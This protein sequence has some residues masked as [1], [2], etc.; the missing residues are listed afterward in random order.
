[1]SVRPEAIVYC[2]GF[3]TSFVLSTTLFVTCLPRRPSLVPT[4]LP[5]RPTVLLLATT[6][7]PTSWL[8]SA[9]VLLLSTTLSEV[10]VAA[11]LIRPR[12]WRRRGCVSLACVL[13]FALCPVCSAA[14]AD[15]RPVKQTIRQTDKS[16]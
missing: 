14:R 9:T 5:W 16:N 3:T 10:L 13:A 7:S 11:R 6:F 15:D 12:R 1:M 4:C 8:F 2:L